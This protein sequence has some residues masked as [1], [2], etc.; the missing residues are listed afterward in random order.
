MYE[1]ARTL[2]GGGGIAR[3]LGD[4][5]TTVLWVHPGESVT[6]TRIYP[7]G[8]SLTCP[9]VRFPTVLFINF[10]YAVYHGVALGAVLRCVIRI[11]ELAW[12]YSL[13]SVADPIRTGGFPRRIK[14]E[15]AR[16]RAVVF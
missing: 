16:S 10:S 15:S 14:D 13:S 5:S 6:S 11:A 1:V 4:R 7:G 3:C 12:V 2:P 8:V 9:G